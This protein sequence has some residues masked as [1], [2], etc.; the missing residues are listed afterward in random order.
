MDPDEFARK[1]QMDDNPWEVDQIQA[2]IAQ[3]I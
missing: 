3:T 2:E 1:I